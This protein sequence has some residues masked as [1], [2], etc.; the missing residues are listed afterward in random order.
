[1]RRYPLRP[2]RQ[3]NLV[4][5]SVNDLQLNMRCFTFTTQ[6]VLLP[7]EAGLTET[8]NLGSQKS[9]GLSLQSQDLTPAV[10]GRNCLPT[11]L[12]DGSRCAVRCHNQT[13]G[14]SILVLQVLCFLRLEAGQGNIQYNRFRSTGRVVSSLYDE[15]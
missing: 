3:P 13:F 11:F 7:A 12:R 10:R 2:W 4:S 1:M 15:C 6:S 8:T 9:K 5:A 14:A